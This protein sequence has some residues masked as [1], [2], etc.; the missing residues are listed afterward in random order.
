[1]KFSDWRW[2]ELDFRG[3]VKHGVLPVRIGVLPEG[4]PNDWPGTE[5]GRT[6]NHA[7]RPPLTLGVLYGTC[8]LSPTFLMHATAFGLDLRFRKTEA[9]PEV[10]AHDAL[11]R[12]HFLML[13]LLR[14]QDS[15][16]NLALSQQIDARCT[17]FSAIWPED[18]V[19]G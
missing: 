10:H 15:Y 7:I 6:R 3:M 8:Y 17:A 13:W 1:M 12:G 19:A 14:Q 4:A 2:R 11:W 9:G 16:F 18:R 5:G